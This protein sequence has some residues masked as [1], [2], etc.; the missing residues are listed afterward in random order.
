MIKC[1][2]DLNAAYILHNRGVHILAGW[3]HPGIPLFIVLHHAH[4]AHKA[5][6]DG[7]KGNQS[8]TP[9]Q[10]EHINQ[11]Q[12]GDQNVGR[13]LRNHVRQRKLQLLCGIHQQRLKLAR[14]RIQDIT[15]GYTGELRRQFCAD[16]LQDCKSRAVT[17]HGGRRV[18]PGAAQIAQ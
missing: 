6:G 10:N 3:Q 7:D 14:R 4:I 15:H 17:E 2:N 9:I 1:L 18:Q 8:N 13:Q 11:H 5:N 16:I 12:D